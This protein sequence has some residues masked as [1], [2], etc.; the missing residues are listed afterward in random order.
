[1]EDSRVTTGAGWLC[2]AVL[3]DLYSWLIIAWS[4]MDRTN[5]ELVNSAL[6]MAIE[7]RLGKPVLAPKQP[8][9]VRGPGTAVF[10][11]QLERE[12]VALCWPCG[13]TSDR[14]E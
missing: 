9:Y 10:A 6:R 8:Q 5:Q 2:L 7:A 12:G 14:L 11:R 3:I 4:M 1:M 13:L